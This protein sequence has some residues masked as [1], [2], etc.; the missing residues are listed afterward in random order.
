MCFIIQNNL[1]CIFIN[2]RLSSSIFFQFHPK[3][4]PQ[5]H[6][7]SHKFD[8]ASL[9]LAVLR[10]GIIISKHSRT[11]S[12]RFSVSHTGWKH[13]IPSVNN[14]T[15][16]SGPYQ[17]S[18]LSYGSWGWTIRMEALPCWDHEFLYILSFIT[19]PRNF[20][21]LYIPDHQAITFPN[22]VWFRCHH[23]CHLH[24][25]DLHTASPCALHA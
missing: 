7:H 16:S 6:P 17:N 1:N 15:K 14:S 13:R 5:S 10:T 22:P 23:L 20:Y 19:A 3:S 21:F 8:E 11:F 18:A 25:C 9:S 24:I 4:L 12:A 2:F